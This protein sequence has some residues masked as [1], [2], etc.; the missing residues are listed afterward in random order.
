MTDYTGCIIYLSTDWELRNVHKKMQ[1]NLKN[2]TVN[3]NLT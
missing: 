3:E 1:K 2:L